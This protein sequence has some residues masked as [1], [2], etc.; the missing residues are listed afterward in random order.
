MGPGPVAKRSAPRL[1]L[2]RRRAARFASGVLVKVFTCD[3]FE[4]HY[5]VGAAA[6]MV[7]ETEERARE[8]LDAEL[9]SGGL[10]GLREDD[11]VMELNPEVEVVFVLVDG[12]Y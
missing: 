8:L 10:P 11:E 7:A 6:V 3:G 9:K 4:G 12:N 5:P 2:E 1:E